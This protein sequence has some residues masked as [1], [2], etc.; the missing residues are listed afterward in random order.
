MKNDNEKNLTT[1][2]NE[3]R[4]TDAIL[5]E[6]IATLLKWFS[7]ILFVSLSITCLASWNLDPIAVVIGYWLVLLVFGTG[8][9]IKKTVDNPS[10]PNLNCSDREVRRLI[11]SKIC[12]IKRYVGLKSKQEAREI[13]QG[14]PF[15][16]AGQ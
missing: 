16:P 3:Q 8:Y 6:N 7:I 14:W 15:I 11:F 1:H 13:F 10:F 5:L 4:I 9:V 2:S 12:Q